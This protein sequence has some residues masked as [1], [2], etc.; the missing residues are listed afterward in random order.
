MEIPFQ[1]QLNESILRRMTLTALRPTRGRFVY[2]LFIV[3]IF[4]WGLI[5]FPWIHGESLDLASYLPVLLIVC[6]FGYAMLVWGPKKQLQGTKLLQGARTGTVGDETIHLETSY[7]TSDLPWDVFTRAK[8]AKQM[9]L[10]YTSTVGST[11]YPFPREF[12]ASDTDWDGFVGLVRRH[13]PLTAPKQ[14]LRGRPW[15]VFLLWLVIFFFV[16][17]AWNVFQPSR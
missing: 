14:G 2:I 17:L 1:G 4:S 3:A 12:F 9:V 5:I 13:A 16:I 8:I 6:A 11:V 10:L 7:G 15:L